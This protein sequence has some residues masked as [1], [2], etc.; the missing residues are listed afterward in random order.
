MLFSFG[1]HLFALLDK[2]MSKDEYFQHFF[3]FF[4]V[5]VQKLEANGNIF[6]RIGKSNCLS[7]SANLLDSHLLEIGPKEPHIIETS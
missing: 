4:C 2:K 5:E 6:L 3:H 7:V 1:G